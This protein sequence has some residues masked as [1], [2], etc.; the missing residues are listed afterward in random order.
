MSDLR[1]RR[2]AAAG[3]VGAILGALG[4]VAGR[5]YFYVIV[6]TH[7]PTI[8]LREARVNFHLALVIAAFVGLASGLVTAELART[9]ARI[10]GVERA[11][12][13]LVLPVLAIAMA[14]M[15]WWP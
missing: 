12:E 11:A 10:A 14:L 4:Y 2:I 15:F 8:I 6:G 1:A 3:Y 9:E 5:A 7:G 13:R